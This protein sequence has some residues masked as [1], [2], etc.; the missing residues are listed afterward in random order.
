MYRRLIGRGVAARR[1]GAMEND[2]VGGRGRDADRARA[3]GVVVTGRSLERCEVCRTRGA[4]GARLTPFTTG[5]LCPGDTR[6][7]GRPLTVP[8]ERRLEPGVAV[9]RGADD[10]ERADAVQLAGLDHRRLRTGQRGRR[11]GDPCCA[12]EERGGDEGE[13]KAATFREQFHDVPFLLGWRLESVVTIR[14]RAITTTA[15]A[16]A[17]ATVTSAVAE[18]TVATVCTTCKVGDCT[19]MPSAAHA[20][21]PADSPSCDPA[22]KH[23]A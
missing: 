8:R 21:A 4:L 5:A 2:V 9:A 23:K 6:R 13:T 17:K 20:S 15:V 19:V 7:A 14:R 10:A 22:R 16:V 1:D 11:E 3:P 18:A 12:D